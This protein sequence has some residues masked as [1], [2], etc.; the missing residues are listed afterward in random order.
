[1]NAEPV[2]S[3]DGVS[4]AYRIWANPAQ[5]LLGPLSARVGASLPGPLGAALRRSAQAGYQDFL[6]LQGVSL[7]VGRGEAV[8][9]IGR[10]GSG[11]S[12]LLQIIA[13]TL[14]PT[15]GTA[16]VRGRV[17]AL[18]ELG[19]GFNTDFTGRENVFLSGAVLGLDQKEMEARFDDVAAF[20]D[21]GEFIEQPVKTYSSGMMMRLAFAVNTCVDPD[22]LIVD[23]ALS[24]GD[25]PFQAKCFRRLRQLIDKGVS[26]LFVS[27]DLGT[28]RSVCSRALWLKNGRSERWG[29]AKVVAKEYEK[30]CWAEQGVR[31]TAAEAAPPEIPL[32]PIPVPATESTVGGPI[33]AALAATHEQ[34]TGDIRERY[35]AGGLRIRNLALFDETGARCSTLRFGQPVRA[36][37]LVRAEHEFTGKLRLG[38]RVRNLKQDFILTVSD[39]TRSMAVSLRKGQACVIALDFTANLTHGNYSIHSSLFAVQNNSTVLEEAYDF[40]DSTIHD[41]IEEACFFAVEPNR[42]VLAVGPVHQQSPYFLH[43]IP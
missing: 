31:M 41:C 20:A 36:A 11:K 40:S 27:H 24:V 19:A 15:R 4:K 13:G 30:Y 23:E 5:R 35:G 9:I 42:P 17:A 29:E 3:V 1:M 12:T 21:I 26:L 25:A 33:I 8:G 32:T 34:F 43:T 6:A 22:I 39:L 10:N 2:I 37:Y 14:Q 18:L 16:R 38:L 28:V 7:E